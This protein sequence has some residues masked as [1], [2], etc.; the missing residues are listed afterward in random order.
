MSKLYLESEPASMER[1]NGD[2]LLCGDRVGG[3]QSRGVF[4]KT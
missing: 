3:L 2:A 4:T 1:V